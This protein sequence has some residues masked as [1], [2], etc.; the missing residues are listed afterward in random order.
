MFSKRHGANVFLFPFPEN[1][2]LQL[3]TI[4]KLETALDIKLI[5]LV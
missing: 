1:E 2:N 3:E 4:V 5:K